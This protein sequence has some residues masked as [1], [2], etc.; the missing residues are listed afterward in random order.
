MAAKLGRNDPCYC[1]SGKKYKA[2]C[3]NSPVATLPMQNQYDEIVSEF[4][5]KKIPYDRI[6]F[7]NHSNF[8][9]QERKDP[10][11]LEKYARFVNERPYS[12]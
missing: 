6:E 4:T 2:C 3:M 7:Y 5:A 1:G 12:E 8:L 10:A 9:A 11:Y